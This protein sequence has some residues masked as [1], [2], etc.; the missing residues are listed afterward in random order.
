MRWLSE[1]GSIARIAS[2]SREARDLDFS[3]V[4]NAYLLISAV[5]LVIKKHHASQET[6]KQY[7]LC[8]DKVWSQAVNL[9]SFLWRL[10]SIVIS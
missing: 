9:C 8:R 6:D 2:F 1:L 7:H 3:C 4:K 5:N 10:S